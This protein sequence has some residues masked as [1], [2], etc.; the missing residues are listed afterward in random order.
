MRVSRVRT[1]RGMN[2]LAS[3]LRAL[4]GD[5]MFGTIGL[6]IKQCAI[7]WLKDFI[8]MVEHLAFGEAASHELRAVAPRPIP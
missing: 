4:P 2:S 8:F 1:Q 3:R 7:P 5:G 6:P